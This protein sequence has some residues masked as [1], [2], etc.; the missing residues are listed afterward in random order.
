MAKILVTGANGKTGQQVVAALGKAGLSARRATRHP[1]AP[2]DVRFD[3]LDPATWDDALGGVQGLFLMRPPAIARID[4]TLAP[5]I[6]AARVAGVQH[7]CF[8]SVA[9]ADRM[10]FIPHAAVERALREGPADWSILRPGFFAQ[11][12]QDAYIH[13]IRHDDR[14]FVPAGR[15]R[16][17]FVDLRDVGSLAA[18]ILAEP[19]RHIGAAYTLTGPVAAT[20][21]EVAEALSQ[22]TGRAITYRA[23][24]VPGYLAHLRKQRLPVAQTLVQTALHVGLRFGQAERVDPTLATQLGRPPRSIFDYVHDHAEAW[25]RVGG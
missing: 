2:G 23:A 16:V 5:L 18:R 8:L 6:A 3:F 1:L 10:R 14:L 11:N 22:T 7:I 21:D 25:V 12:L 17:A 20:F 4:S 24:S 15:G 13:D 9:G 19:E